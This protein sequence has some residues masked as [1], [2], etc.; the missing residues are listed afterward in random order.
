M[1]GRRTI[2]VTLSKETD[3]PMRKRNCPRAFDLAQGR[4]CRSGRAARHARLPS[5]L[6][7]VTLQVTQARQ[8]KGDIDQYFHLHPGRSIGGSP[9]APPVPARAASFRRLPGS[10]APGPG[11]VPR[12]RDG[13]WRRSPQALPLVIG[14]SPAG[15][16]LSSGADRSRTNRGPPRPF[17]FHVAYRPASG[18]DGPRM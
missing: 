5:R 7:H 2:R 18:R 9:S 16:R 6:S 17:A 14:L 15:R 13:M 11:A 8:D 4:K 12:S 10:G 1:A 3:A